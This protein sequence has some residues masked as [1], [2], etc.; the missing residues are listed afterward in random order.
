MKLTLLPGCPTV[1][2]FERKELGDNQYVIFKTTVEE[3]TLT[4]DNTPVLEAQLRALKAAVKSTEEQL[5]KAGV[6][7]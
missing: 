1:T 4:S 3:L 7:R 5:S 2:G 6:K